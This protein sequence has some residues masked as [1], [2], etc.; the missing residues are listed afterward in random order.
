[1]SVTI[2]NNAILKHK[3]GILRETDTPPDSFRRLIS[4]IS[5]HL[6]CEAAKDL[7]CMSVDIEAPFARTKVDRLIQ[8]ISLISIMRAGNGMLDSILRTWPNSSVGHVGIYRDKFLSNTVEYY[9]KVPNGIEDSVVFV[10]DPIVATGDTAIAC[11]ERLYEFGCKDIRFISVLSSESGAAAL[12]S[13][14]PDIKLYTL[15]TDDQLTDEG[16]LTPGIGDVG[17]RYYNT[18]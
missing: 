4:E 2:V 16:Y 11:M 10:L 1:M 13:H 3:L 9:F 18:Q 5:T 6:F 12:M 8:K 7:P 15:S 14:Y 17:S